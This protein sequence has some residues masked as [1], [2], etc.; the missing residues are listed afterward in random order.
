MPTGRLGVDAE[1]FVDRAVEIVDIVDVGRVEVGL[2]EHRL[3]ARHVR[4]E[5]VVVGDEGGDP[6][7]VL[8]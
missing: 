2:V 4:R 3:E 5:V 8:G 7:V 1:V 6:R